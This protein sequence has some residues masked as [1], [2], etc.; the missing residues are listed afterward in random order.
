MNLPDA[1]LAEARERARAEGR[2]VTSLVEEGLRAVLHSDHPD[3]VHEPLVSDG[4]PGDQ[5]LLVD[6]ADRDA[7]WAALET[8]ERR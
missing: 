1:L 6:L 5:G 7:V 8:D 4:T 2:T 3:R